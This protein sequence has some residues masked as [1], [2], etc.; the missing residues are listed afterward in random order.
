MCLKHILGKSTRLIT[1]P[2]KTINCDN[3]SLKFQKFVLILTWGAFPNERPA[4]KLFRNP[5][6]FSENSSQRK[7]SCW[8]LRETF[9]V[10]LRNLL[11]KVRKVKTQ[12]YTILLGKKAA[13]VALL[14]RNKHYTCNMKYN[15]SQSVRSRI[16]EWAKRFPIYS[17][18][19]CY[20]SE[21]LR[22]L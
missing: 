6:S 1:I 4:K 8:L 15:L 21:G 2:I 19:T 14:S 10:W 20:T 12:S 7:T 11:I 16:E 5:S 22:I 3:M 13:R 18:S 17:R 9:A